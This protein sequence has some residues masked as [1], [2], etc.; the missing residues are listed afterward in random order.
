MNESF[1]LIVG[2]TMVEVQ[3]RDSI[4]ITSH[5]KQGIR[6]LSVGERMESHARVVL[7]IVMS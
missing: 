7:P 3:N 6:R 2:K 4:I 5:K 1:H